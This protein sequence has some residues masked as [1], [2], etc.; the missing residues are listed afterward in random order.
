MRCYRKTLTKLYSAVE[1]SMNCSL[2]PAVR[3]A[4]TLFRPMV[5][6]KPS[7]SRAEANV[8][9]S[10]RVRASCMNTSQSTTAEPA[11]T[12][13]YYVSS[14]LYFAIY[15]HQDMYRYRNRDVQ[16]DIYI[17]C[18]VNVHKNT[19]IHIARHWWK[20]KGVDEAHLRNSCCTCYPA[21]HGCSSWCHCGRHTWSPTLCFNGDKHS[22]K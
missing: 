7:S 13:H 21:P 14:V 19:V 17:L 1:S 16:R 20:N 6:R 11:G 22:L 18:T 15:K 5:R 2:R 8:M 10:T 4:S 3:R 12:S 9:A